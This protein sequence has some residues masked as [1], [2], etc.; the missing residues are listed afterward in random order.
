MASWSVRRRLTYLALFALFFALLAG[1][2]LFFLWPE[3]SCFDGRKNQEEL[4]IDCGGPPQ[5]GCAAVCQSEVRDLKVWWSRVVKLD[6]GIFETATLVENPNFE[7]G[8]T[9]APYT[10]RYFDA[11]GVLINSRKGRVN[12]RPGERFVVFESNINVGRRIPVRST[13]QWGANPAWYRAA[14]DRELPDFPWQIID[15]TPQPARLRATIESRADEEIPSLLVV[16]TLSDSNQ[17]LLA[18]SSTVVENLASD[19]RREIVF[20]WPRPLADQPTVF[21]LY[22]HLDTPFTE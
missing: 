16:A 10:I 13:F 14:I 3:P 20:S 8:V 18:V 9:G 21:K 1:L 11:E 17:N 15:F 4:D 19:A 12:L 22:P 5:G 2:I 7:I 6:D